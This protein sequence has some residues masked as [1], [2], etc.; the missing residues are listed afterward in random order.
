MLPGVAGTFDGRRT[1]V[2]SCGTT[3]SVHGKVAQTGQKLFLSIRPEALRLVEDSE[4]PVL[5]AKLVLRE[6]LGQIQRLHATLPDGTQIRVSTL[7]S[8]QVAAT[9]GASL[10][11]AYDP[12]QI[13]VYPAP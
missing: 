6:F 3:I 10:A 8:L 12:A 7:G 13:T 4:G 2:A 5:Q 9:A 11:F 1:E